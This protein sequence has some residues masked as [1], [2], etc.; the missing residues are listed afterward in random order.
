MLAALSDLDFGWTGFFRIWFSLWLFYCAYFI[1][2]VWWLRQMGGGVGWALAAVPVYFALPFLVPAAGLA[3]APTGTLR[4]L[5]FPFLW[6]GFEFLVRLIFLR[7]NW[8]IVGL[9][10]ADYPLLS[11]AAS[12][13]GPEGVSFIAASASVL[14]VLLVTLQKR[15]RVLAAAGALLLT[16]AVLAAGFIRSTGSDSGVHTLKLGLVQP[17]IPEDVIWT[18]QAREPF[19][20]RIMNLINRARAGAPDVIVLPEGAVNGLARYDNRLTDFVRSTVIRTRT[21]LL[22]GSYDRQGDAFFNVAIYIDPYDT[23]TTYRKIRLA[24]FVE[25]EPELFPYSRPSN[26]LRF[27]AGTERTVFATV[28]GWR[29]STM[30][31]L[32]DS[33]PELARDF[34]LGGAQLLVGLES[35]QR[36]EGTSEPLQHLRRARLVAIAAG[37]PMARCANSGISCL[38]NPLGRVVKMLDEGR[39]EAAVVDAQLLSLDTLYR[40]TGDWPWFAGLLIIGF[41]IGLA[42]RAARR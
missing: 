19:L 6:T 13:C 2:S 22:F 34:A 14:V 20:D 24:P 33:M 7:L 35:T 12:V 37:L 9:P 18:P 3:L 29:F 4:L 11:Q 26:W 41:G 21:P 1:A 25:Y 15:Q 32:E 28:P 17:N 8:T 36:F 5:A 38:I 31:C 39:P 40:F 16:I 23:V 42:G 27:T 10:L 30:I